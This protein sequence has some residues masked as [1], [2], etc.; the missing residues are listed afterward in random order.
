MSL[1]P[2]D[3]IIDASSYLHEL[4]GATLRWWVLRVS[5]G[6]FRLLATGLPHGLAEIFFVSTWYVDCPVR[7]Q[8][9]RI[10]VATEQETAELLRC[11]PSGLPASLKREDHLVIGCDEG[12]G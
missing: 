3:R 4:D 11:L 12:F 2:P 7:M 8:N 6:E 9:V 5:H 1:K 10:R